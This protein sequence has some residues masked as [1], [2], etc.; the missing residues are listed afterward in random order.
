MEAK[1]GRQ[2]DV[3]SSYRDW[4]TQLKLW[5][6]YQNHVPGAPFALHPDDSMHC[7][8]LAFDTDDQAMV[9][10][11]SAYG[12]RQTALAIGEPWH[13]D[14]LRAFDQHYG[15][16][17]D[18]GSEPFP[19]TQPTEV[20][21]QEEDEDMALKGAI[22]KRAKD[23]AAVYLLF[24]DAS[25]FAAE[26]TGT[27]AAYNNALALTWATGNWPT[28]TEAHANVIKASLA[29]VRTGGA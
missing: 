12:W 17:A 29:K 24:N 6:A 21:E 10:S 7:K 1:A 22:Y 15:E 8:G 4:D 11:L 23:G 19:P 20:H 3:N 9:K 5:A 18:S 16:P 28:V 27:P 2:L 25:G 26:H 13:F 14:Y